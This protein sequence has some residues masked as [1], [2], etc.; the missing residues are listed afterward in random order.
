MPKQLLLAELK[1]VEL[2][3]QEQYDRGEA[4]D[5][6]LAW[7]KIERRIV[8]DMVGIGRKEQNNE[9]NELR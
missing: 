5:M 3:V 8:E 1:A 4:T 6:E 2:D 9:Q 7:A